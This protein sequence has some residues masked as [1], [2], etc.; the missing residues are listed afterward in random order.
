MK[1]DVKLDSGL[2]MEATEMEC[3]MRYCVDVMGKKSLTIGDGHVL[4]VGNRGRWQ[5]AT[6]HS[7]QEEESFGSQTKWPLW[8]ERGARATHIRH[9]PKH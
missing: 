3:D 1:T 5:Q 6:G 4:G 7:K 9:P 2:A 8:V